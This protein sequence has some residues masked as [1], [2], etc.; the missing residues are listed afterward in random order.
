MYIGKGSF[1]YAVC[2]YI[3]DSYLYTQQIVVIRTASH[4]N[5][6]CRGDKVY[7]NYVSESITLIYI[8]AYYIG[9]CIEIDIERAYIYKSI[10]VTF[11]QIEIYK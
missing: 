6:K 3:Y 5:I 1:I 7:P 11:I 9:S 4:F 2:G 10:Y 8:Y